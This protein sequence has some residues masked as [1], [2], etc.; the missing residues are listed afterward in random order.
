MTQA[1][2]DRKL[3]DIHAVTLAMG[4]EVAGDGGTGP[5]C[6]RAVMQRIDPQPPPVMPDIYA[7]RVPLDTFNGD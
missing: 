3:D 6:L 1:E 5:E 4:H 7:G 2:R